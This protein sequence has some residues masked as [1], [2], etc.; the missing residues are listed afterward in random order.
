MRLQLSSSLLLINFCVACAGPIQGISSAVT[1]APLIPTI[2]QTP[3]VLPHATAQPS[4]TTLP[5][6]T[7]PATDTP[8][9]TMT[10]VP[11]T[12]YVF[13]VAHASVSYGKVHHDYP[14]TDIFCEEGSQYVAVTAG[15]IDAIVAVDRWE[16]ATDVPADRSGLAVAMVG[17]DGVRYYGSH[18]SAIAA[19]L[20]VGQHVEVGM[21]LGSTGK[22]G[23]ARFTPAHLHFGISRPTT[24]DDWEVRRGQISPYPY[25]KAWENGESL[26][27]VFE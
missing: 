20:T 17:D 1:Q 10:A 13:P 27:P 21:V 6:S 26:T 24:P 5:T 4:V 8:T 9:T 16:P 3:T 11:V 2:T 22:T 7:V 18:L 14:A 19:G 25:L 12:R 23:N 15:V